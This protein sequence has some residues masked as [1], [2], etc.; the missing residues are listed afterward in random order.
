[1]LA[2]R[3]PNARWVFLD[4]NAR[5]TA[6]LETAVGELDLADRVRVVAD[7]AERAARVDDYRG[8]FDL[9]VSR[10][11]G[12]PAVTAECACGFLAVGGRLVVSEPPDDAEERWPDG[13]LGDL[14]LADRG[15]R[16]AVRL[17]EQV[18]PAPERFP[19]RV[20]VPAKRPLW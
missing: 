7:R 15:R 2:E 18:T 10:S 4:S 17:L 9:V 16:G 11:F 13:P 12:P 6:F 14:G 8:A 20:G 3:W 5:R 19:R 1:V